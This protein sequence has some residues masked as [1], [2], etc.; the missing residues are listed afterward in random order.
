VQLPARATTSPRFGFGLIL[1]YSDETGVSLLWS[2]PYEHMVRYLESLLCAGVHTDAS[3]R[4]MAP[5]TIEL[6][7]ARTR[8]AHPYLTTPDHTRHAREILGPNPS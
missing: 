4:R 7:D 6:S 8:G 3:C 2:Q 5:K 1:S